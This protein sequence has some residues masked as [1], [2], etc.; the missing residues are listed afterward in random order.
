MRKIKF[1]YF[2]IGGVML[3]FD[4]YFKT[5]TNKFNIDLNEF[6]E[7]WKTDNIWA[8][9]TIGKIGPQDVWNKAIK[10]FNLKNADDYNFAESWMSDYIG[11]P[12]VHKLASDLSKK[13]KV[14]LISNLY[15]GMMPRLIET[16]KV[17]DVDYSALVLSY[18]VGLDK[19]DKKIFEVA[20]KKAGVLPEEILYID[21]RKDFLEVATQVGWQTVWFNT[22]NID[23]SI[24]EIEKIL[25]CSI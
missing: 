10:K 5:A 12:E 1:I 24:K 7:L 8:D 21:D 9:I 23:K 19:K 4:N 14:G 25:G 22:E 11:R 16:G 20:T 17:A 2:D 18:E 3:N 15:S 6:L 13:Y